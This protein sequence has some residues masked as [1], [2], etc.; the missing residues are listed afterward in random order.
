MMRLRLTA[1]I[2]VSLEDESVLVD[3]LELLVELPPQPAST[4]LPARAP[5]ARM[6]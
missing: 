6:N 2:I 5:A 1:L 4:A 3:V